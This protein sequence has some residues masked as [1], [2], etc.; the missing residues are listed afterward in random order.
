[1]TVKEEQSAKAPYPIEVTPSGI[2]MPVKEEQY[3]KAPSP[4]EVTLSGIVMPVKEEQ[5]PKALSPIE[6]TLF[7]IEY[8]PFF[9][10]GQVRSVF[11]SL[12]NNTPSIEA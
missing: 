1:M 3:S 2:V 11:L 8:S 9:P 4:I 7:G 12:S 10:P 6:V 5:K